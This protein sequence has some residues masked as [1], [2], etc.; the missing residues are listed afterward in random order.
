MIELYGEYGMLYASA[1]CRTLRR[2]CHV[3]GRCY[4][5]MCN[6]HAD[7]TSHTGNM[8]LTAE[9]HR[10]SEIEKRIR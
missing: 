3:Q 2:I 7:V 9:T 1:A 8:V 10:L 4:A 5:C 6:V